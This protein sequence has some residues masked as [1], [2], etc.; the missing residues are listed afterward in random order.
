LNHQ[1]DDAESIALK[2]IRN[3]VPR[4][5]LFYLIEKDGITF[6]HNDIEMTQ[7]IGVSYE[8]TFGGSDVYERDWFE[9][10]L[11]K[12]QACEKDVGV[13]FFARLGFCDGVTA[14][15]HDQKE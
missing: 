3:H 13:V 14:Q 8:A 10:V 7:V 6:F 2:T 1:F 4:G 5:L 15:K 11:S 12:D 9:A